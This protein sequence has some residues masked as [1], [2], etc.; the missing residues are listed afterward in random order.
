MITTF[1]QFQHKTSF[2]LFL[3]E[4]RW[5][6]QTSAH[7]RPPEQSEEIQS[8]ESTTARDPLLMALKFSISISVDEPRVHTWINKQT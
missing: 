5:R 8:I 6:S 3:F 1:L 7:L 2:K 4:L